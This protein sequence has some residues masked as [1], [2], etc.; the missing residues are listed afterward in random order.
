L[1]ATGRDVKYE[2]RRV[3][4]GLPTA[5]VG[6]FVASADR[7]PPWTTLHRGTSTALMDREVAL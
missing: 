6:R 5:A 2:T 4:H 3:E 7:P 1:A